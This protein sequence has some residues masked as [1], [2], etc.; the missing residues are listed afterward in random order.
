MLLKEQLDFIV[1]IKENTQVHLWQYSDC[2]KS[3]ESD[4]YSY[5]C[6][7]TGYMKIK[8]RAEN[9][10]YIIKMNVI[11]IKIIIDLLLLWQFTG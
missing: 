6:V 10:I 4:K 2:L 11:E 1:K 8:V 7:L 9:K 3:T 5:H